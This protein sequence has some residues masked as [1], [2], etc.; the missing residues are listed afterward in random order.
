MEGSRP[1]IWSF[2]AFMSDREVLK[3]AL[4]STP[5][6]LTLP[7]LEVLAA[8][9]TQS[10]SHLLQC[11]RCQA[12]LEMLKSFES[13]EPLPGEGA[14]VAWISSHL[15]RQVD[16]IKNPSRQTKSRSTSASP[17]WMARLFGTGRMRYSVLGAAVAL[18]AITSVLVL[19]PSKEPEL[20]ASLGNQPVYRSQ[21]VQVVG[22]AG[23]VAEVPKTLD[24]QG[25]PGAKT[26][27]VVVMEVDQSPLWTTEI[28]GTFVTI[29]DAV[30]GRIV[31]NKPILWQVTALDSAGTVLASSSTQRFLYR[32]HH[33]ESNPVLPQ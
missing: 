21:Q 1:V 33:G 2:E 29:P 4:A 22:P 16:Q 32:E 8:G 23:D 17:S 9:Q 3:S 19:R 24:W 13:T 31:V 10:N 30:R 6:C 27:K 12:E 11:P 14:A 18:V 15:E 7:Q 26:Y 5:D 25:F 20:R 28:S